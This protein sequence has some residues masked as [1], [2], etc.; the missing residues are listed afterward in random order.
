[1]L[2]AITRVLSRGME[3]REA[4]LGQ[5]D[6]FMDYLASGGW[7]SWTGANVTTTSAM[8]HE[9][10]WACVT[11]RSNSLAQL[12]IITYRVRE[13][14]GKDRAK[15]HYLYDL[16]RYK[17][18][19]YLTAF[20]WKRLM[21]MWICIHGNAY[22]QMEVSGRGQTTALYPWNPSRVTVKWE[23]FEGSK[24]PFYYFRRDAGEEPTR[25]PYFY[26]IHL[27][28]PGTDGFMGLSPIQEHK[29]T[30][31]MGLAVQEH[32]SR[33]FK[34][35]AA[36]RGILSPKAGAPNIPKEQLDLMKERWQ[37]NYGG[38][39]NAHK[40]AFMPVGMDYQPVSISMVDSQYA[41]IAQLNVPQICRIFGV[42]PHKVFDLLRST[43]NNIEHQDIEWRLDYQGP[44]IVNWED[45]LNGTL[46]SDFERSSVYIEF[47]VNA[48][49]RA[50]SA[51][52]SEYYT[53]ALAGAPWMTQDE[54]RHLES[55]NPTGAP[56]ADKFP[57]T[58]NAPGPVQKTQ[59][60]Q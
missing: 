37:E 31:G 42:P 1:V 4:S 48:L 36:L 3:A 5:L 38:L 10:V 46:L 14:G 24:I 56:G 35:G 18:N 45:E 6:A 21:E 41:E 25:V 22:S 58:N 40:T 49:M 7:D 13:D 8:R 16:L 15:N 26:M 43:N 51:S 19:P 28:G 2:S 55:Q 57:I 23:E 50:D 60:G 32:G 53:K 54:V 59:G 33:F 52:R 20:A 47:L 39:T 29:Q 44:E 9:A 12:P 34:N 27:R 30:I 11:V 17:V